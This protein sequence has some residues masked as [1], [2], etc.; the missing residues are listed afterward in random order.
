MVLIDHRYIKIHMLSYCT[1]FLVPEFI[2][3]NFYHVHLKVPLEMTFPSL[4]DYTARKAS[5]RLNKF[6]LLIISVSS[7]PIVCKANIFP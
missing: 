5:F 2:V 7:L 1:S 4:I 6:H 3:F